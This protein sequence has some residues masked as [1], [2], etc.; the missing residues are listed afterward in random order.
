MTPLMQRGRVKLAT[1]CKVPANQHLE[2]HKD[3]ILCVASHAAS[4]TLVT[5]SYDGMAGR[6]ASSGAPRLFSFPLH[7]T[8]QFFAYVNGTETENILI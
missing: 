4:N 1:T 3:D 5:G 6:V 7:S 8:H 2:G